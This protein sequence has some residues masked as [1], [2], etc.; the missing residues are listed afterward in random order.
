MIH[1]LRFFFIILLLVNISPNIYAGSIEPKRYFTP[2]PFPHEILKTQPIQEKDKPEKLLVRSGTEVASV[3]LSGHVNRAMTYA[4]NGVKQ[5]L[6]HVDNDNSSSRIKVY[7]RAKVSDKFTIGA[8]FSFE[9]QSNDSSITDISSDS[10]AVHFLQRETEAVFISKD[11]GTFSIGHG[12][13]RSDTTS[14]NDLSKTDV[15]ALGCS[16]D[17]MSGGLSFRKKYIKGE[18]NKGPIV[19]DVYNPMDGLSRRDRFRWDSPD[20]YGFSIG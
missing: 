10:G 12:H 8:N 3:S 9:M 18:A 1:S 11:F 14:E 16:A 17:A 15:V 6:L 2:I 20:V 13:T 5:R 19:S 4:D 7:S